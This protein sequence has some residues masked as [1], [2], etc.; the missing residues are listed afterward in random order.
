M[1]VCVLCELI[2][3]FLAVPCHHEQKLLI[4]IKSKL[5]PALL[6][7]SKVATMD[8]VNVSVPFCARQHKV[9][10]FSSERH[11]TNSL[12]L[13]LQF[14][15]LRLKELILV[16][17][18]EYKYLHL[19]AIHPDL[20]MKKTC[21]RDR[22]TNGFTSSSTLAYVSER[23]DISHYE[24]LIAEDCFTCQLGGS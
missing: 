22:Q 12:Y 23:F 24:T 5:F 14:P 9:I 13:L 1:S 20:Q 11:F 8:F 10:E 21:S 6:E 19:C 18:S 17:L 15:T 7:A 2:E 16:Q 4:H 3:A